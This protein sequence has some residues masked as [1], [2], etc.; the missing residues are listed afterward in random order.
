MD[1]M[2]RMKAEKKVTVIMVSHDINLA[3]MYADTL[4]LINQ[5]RLVTYGPPQDVLTYETLEAAYGCS[6]LVDDNPLGN[7]PRVTP[8]P[9]RYL[10]T[11]TLQKP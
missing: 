4:M 1:M 8:V 7:Q 3:A 6:L 5:G 9:G 11:E 10:K 2:E